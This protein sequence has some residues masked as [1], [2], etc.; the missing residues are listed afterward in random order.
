MYLIYIYP[1]PSRYRYFY[2]R[3]LYIFS[4]LSIHPLSLFLIGLLLLYSRIF[5]VYHSL[6]FTHVVL[7]PILVFSLIFLCTYIH[8]LCVYS[9]IWCFC[10]PTI[11]FNLRSFDLLVV[12]PLTNLFHASNIFLYTSLLLLTLWI[13]FYFF[14]FCCTLLGYI[15]V[16]ILYLK[17]FINIKIDLFI[18]SCCIYYEIK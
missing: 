10:E 7:S 18:L 5:L 2:S 3:S 12:F 8:I 13:L 1:A 15:V 16:Y 14:F 17:F 6:W 11:L 9:F 4:P